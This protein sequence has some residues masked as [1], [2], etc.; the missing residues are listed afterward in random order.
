MRGMEA[1]E[2]KTYLRDNKYF[3]TLVNEVDGSLTE[4]I[5]GLSPD[6]KDLFMLLQSKRLA[7]RMI[8]EAVDTDINLGN[9]ATR[10]LEGRPIEGGIL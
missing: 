7:I 10:E 6:N 5:L 8:L 9:E 1:Q 3:P 4:Q 2:F